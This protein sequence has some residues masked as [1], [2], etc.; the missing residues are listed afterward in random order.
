MAMT[1]LDMV[2]KFPGDAV[3]AR[4]VDKFINGSESVVLK[5]LKFVNGTSFKYQ[6]YVRDSLGTVTTRKI[7]ASYSTDK[8]VRTPRDEPLTLFGGNVQTDYAIIDVKG[9]S[10]RLDELDAKMIAAGKYFDKLF[11][12][13]DPTVTGHADELRGLK[14]R[15]AGTQ[16][17]YCG[18]NGGALTLALLDA[19]IDSVVGA[20]GNKVI[21]SNRTV[22]RKISQLVKDAAGG[23]S[24]FDAQGQLTSYNGCPI[25]CV[26]ED[27][28][29]AE[30]LDFTETRGTSSVTTSLYIVRY[31]STSDDEF[32]QG[33]Q[34]N[35]FMVLRPPS[36]QG[37]YVLEVAESLMGLGMFH[38]RSAA[39]IGGI[40]NQ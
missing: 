35:S 2:N 40:L 36:H 10:A 24:V 38:P 28:S 23:S 19:A 18:T 26:D 13:G 15:I 25:E 11:F 7:G 17:S 3:R 33:I 39:R 37:T 29:F 34:G 1:I 22:R 8:S 5:R 21:H 9:D 31:G 4:M 20:N 12:N 6:Y 32:V 27:E 14:K 16:V 30:I